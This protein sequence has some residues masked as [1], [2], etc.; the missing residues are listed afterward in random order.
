MSIYEPRR[1]WRPHP[2]DV[3]IGACVAL[4]SLV[5]IGAFTLVLWLMRIGAI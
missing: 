4:A 3:F 5:N 1:P 2:D